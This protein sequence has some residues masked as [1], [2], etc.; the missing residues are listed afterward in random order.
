MSIMVTGS[1]GFIGARIVR[2][3]VKRGQQVVCFDV[4]PPRPNLAPY[5]DSIDVYRGDVTQLP[6]L[7]EA[8]NAHGVTRI[9][10]MAA[11]LPPR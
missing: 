5:M 6:Q 2:K 8:V 7:L 4:I 1:T 11:L 10:H 9:I 3:L